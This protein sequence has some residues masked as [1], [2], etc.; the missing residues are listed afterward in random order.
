MRRCSRSGA[1]SVWMTGVNGHARFWWAAA[2]ARIASSAGPACF[3][4]DLPEMM[5]VTSSG[6]FI[7]ILHSSMYL[8]GG[9]FIVI[10]RS[11]M[12]L[13]GRR[14]QLRSGSRGRAVALVRLL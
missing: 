11:S 2:T 10:L 5:A 4:P 8:R 1:K 12:H 7:M 13:R 3:A 14:R 6:E 9:E